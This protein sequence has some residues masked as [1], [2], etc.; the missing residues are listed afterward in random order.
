LITFEKQ[1]FS[2][3]LRLRLHWELS[4]YDAS[5]VLCL[6]IFLYLFCKDF[7]RNLCWNFE[8]NAV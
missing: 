2:N 5:Q 1:I 3:K 8:E 4:L 6:I 7:R